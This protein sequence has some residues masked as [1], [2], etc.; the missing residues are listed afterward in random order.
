MAMYAVS[1]S[2]EDGKVFIRHKSQ[3]VSVERSDILWI[4]A[5][6]DYATIHTTSS[7]YTVKKTLTSLEEQL[8]ATNFKR[9]HRSYIV[10]MAKVDKIDEGNL[11]S[12]D[13]LIPVSRA[14]KTEVLSFFKL[15]D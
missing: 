12:G 15:L 13:M 7:R 6:G 5:Q 1:I 11:I 10:N 9:V 8:P 4:E 2:S 14:K 3:H